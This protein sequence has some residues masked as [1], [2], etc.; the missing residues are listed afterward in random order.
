MMKNQFLKVLSIIQTRNANSLSIIGLGNPDRADDGFGIALASQ[1]K[2]CSPNLIFSERER[3]VEGIVIDLLERKDIETI[4]FVDVADFGKAPGEIEIFGVEAV[5][6]IEPAMSTHKVPLSFL[7]GI[8]HQQGKMPL[9]LG[10]QP[11]S[12]KF[13][14][15]MSDPLQRLLSFLVAFFSDF[16]KENPD[17]LK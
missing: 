2:Q 5:E 6:Q 10:V 8:I 13:M 9:L 7:M 17:S 16:Y 1:L 3:S 4:L 14:E 15:K 12:L 11:L